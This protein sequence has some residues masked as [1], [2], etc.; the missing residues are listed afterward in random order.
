MLLDLKRHKIFGKVIL[1]KQI[2]NKSKMKKAKFYKIISNNIVEWILEI[3]T[4]L[5]SKINLVHFYGVTKI[6]KL[7]KKRFLTN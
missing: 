1:R 5:W 4:C 6:Q 2:N 3:I 7:H